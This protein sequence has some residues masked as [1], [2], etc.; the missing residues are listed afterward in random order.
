MKYP[1]PSLLLI[2]AIFEMV[3]C[4]SGISIANDAILVL[5]SS[6][7]LNLVIFILLLKNAWPNLNL[8]L[9]VT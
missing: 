7:L 6:T 1:F 5:W 8:D 4:H 3:T 2:A 9:T